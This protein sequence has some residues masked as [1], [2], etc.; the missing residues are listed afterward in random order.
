MKKLYNLVW[1]MIYEVTTQVK[2]FGAFFVVSIFF[3][4]AFVSTYV[5]PFRLSE[6]LD[7]YARS[8]G[9]LDI[10]ITCN[11]DHEMNMIKE[12][13]VVMYDYNDSNEEYPVNVTVYA[14]NTLD[15]FN[16]IKILREKY[17]YYFAVFYDEAKSLN[18][19][20]VVTYMIQIFFFTI[21]TLIMDYL[22]VNMYLQKRKYF[23][24]IL[25]T[26]GMSDAQ[27]YGFVS[28]MIILLQTMAWIASNAIIPHINSYIKNTVEDIFPY[29]TINMDVRL[30][31]QFICWGILV[32]IIML[33][34]LIE[35][36]YSR[37][38][39]ICLLL[40]RGEE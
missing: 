36:I 6:S 8:E 2:F 12:M 17:I 16:S 39:N 34:T 28:L 37:K 24:A 33:S 11:D 18:L 22:S 30:Q 19:I 26:Q 3:V 1:L 27:L 23:L 5:L 9:V 38:K 4:S 14:E 35:N 25:K 21:I 40:N 32:I 29:I 15:Y 31:D 10:V 13:P 7:T 20:K